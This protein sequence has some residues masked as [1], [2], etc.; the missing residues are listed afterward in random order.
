MALTMLRRSAGSPFTT[1]CM[2]D[3][4]LPPGGHPTPSYDRML[5]P[6]AAMV[7]ATSASRPD[8]SLQRTS[9]HATWGCAA[10]PAPCIGSPMS[11]TR[12]R[13]PAAINRP[14]GELG[15]GCSRC[16]CR[17]TNWASLWRALRVVGRHFLCAS[18]SCA[19]MSSGCSASITI[20]TTSALLS[21]WSGGTCTPFTLAPFI[22][23]PTSVC[24]WYAKSTTVAPLGR[25]MGCPEGVN[26]NTPWPNRSSV[27]QSTNSRGG[28]VFRNSFC[29]SR[30]LVSQL[31][32]PASS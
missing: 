21:L 25:R 26:T 4:W 28:I 30:M 14:S 1:N 9:S 24:R 12:F 5:C 18:T 32:R 2:N 11:S 27:T 23:L 13:I 6:W 8:R 20:S 15:S 7:L 10:L 31:T 29:H 19:V 3:C 16:S 17:F 22:W